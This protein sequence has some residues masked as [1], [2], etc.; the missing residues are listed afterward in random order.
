METFHGIIPWNYTPKNSGMQYEKYGQRNFWGGY[1]V[2][3]KL[4]AGGLFRA[5]TD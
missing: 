5:C 3:G 2:N 1:D 4:T